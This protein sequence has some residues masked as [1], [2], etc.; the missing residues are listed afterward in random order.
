MHLASHSVT[1][2][3]VALPVYCAPPVQ[4][5]CWALA[6]ACAV[7]RNGADVYLKDVDRAVHRPAAED[8]VRDGQ[9]WA[10]GGG[11]AVAVADRQRA[12]TRPTTLSTATDWLDSCPDY[13]AGSTVILASR[14]TIR[15]AH[16]PAAAGRVELPDDQGATAVGLHDLYLQ[17]VTGAIL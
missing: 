17:A 13:R 12:V 4:V 1:H 11:H 5:G 6:S 14:T 9:V 2:V 15:S 7:H 3:D 10:V 8:A 16:P